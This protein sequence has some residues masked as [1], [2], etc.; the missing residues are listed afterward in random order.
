MRDFAELK[1]NDR[2]KRVERAPPSLEVVLEFEQEFGVCLPLDYIN[3]LTYSNGG[4]P[5]LDSIAPLERRDI[6]MRAIN[7]FFY[8]NEDQESPASLWAAA[9]A[10]RPILGEKQIPIAADGGGNP[11]VLDLSE[12]TPKVAAYLLDEGLVRVEIAP[13][14]SDFINRLESDPDM[15]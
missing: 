14:F 7:R 6:A 15:I 9:R 10:W 8:L 1:L 13:S 11:F 4:H 5:E 3:L 12:A 2:G